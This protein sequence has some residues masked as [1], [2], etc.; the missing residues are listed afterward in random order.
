MQTE[1][2]ERVHAIR[3]QVMADLA[4]IADYAN[5]LGRSER[6]ILSY[7]ERGL[8]TISIG[9]KCYIVLSLASDYWR[10]RARQRPEPAYVD[11]PRRMARTPRETATA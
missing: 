8:P 9:R 3:V 6:T 5:A 11:A 10:S 4:S 7:I 2:S 1:Q